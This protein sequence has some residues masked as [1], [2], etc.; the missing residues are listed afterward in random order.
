[1]RNSE[2]CGAM[3][4]DMLGRATKALTAS[5]RVAYMDLAA[6]WRRLEAEA[7]AFEEKAPPSKKPLS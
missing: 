5:E 7:R 1:M 2:R 4:A 6:G 3:A